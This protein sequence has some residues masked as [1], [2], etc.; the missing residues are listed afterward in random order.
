MPSKVQKLHCEFATYLLKGETGRD[1]EL[2]TGFVMAGEVTDEVGVG[3]GVA[4]VEEDEAGAGSTEVAG[5]VED[6]SIGTG[7]VFSTA[8]E[9]LF[10][11]AAG[12]GGG[13]LA[14]FDDRVLKSIGSGF[15]AA[16]LAEDEEP[17]SGIELSADDE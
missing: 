1:E 11:G 12:D 14:V 13:C 6:V 7:L 8:E 3:S 15:A 2:S 5:D 17:A 10:E 4:G 9:G 16:T